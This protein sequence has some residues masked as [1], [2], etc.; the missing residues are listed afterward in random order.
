[1]SNFFSFLTLVVFLLIST[2]PSSARDIPDKPVDLGAQSFEY[3]G[4]TF[5]VLN[6]SN[7][8][9]WH[10]YWKNPGDSGLP[11]RKKFIVADDNGEE[12]K[13]EIENLE[14]P[15]PRRYIEDGDIL[16]YGHS[17]DYSLFFSPTSE[18]LQEWEGKDFTVRSSWLVCRHVCIPG[19]GEVKGQW[20]QGSFRA[21]APTLTLDRSTLIDRLNS[22]PQ[23]RDFPDELDIVLAKSSPD[24]REE[25]ALYY[26]FRTEGQIGNNR[27]L[28][29]PF[30][31]DLLGFKREYLFQDRSGHYYGRMLINWDGDFATPPVN[32]PEDGNLPTPIE[33]SFLLFNPDN[34]KTE[35]ITKTFR[36][37][38]IDHANRAE[39]L[40]SVLSTV[41]NQSGPEDISGTAAGEVRS[42]QVVDQGRTQASLLFYLVLALIG[43]AILNL[44]PCVLPVI[45]LKLFDLIKHRQKTRGQILKHN[46]A[47]TLGVLA[48][49]MA[50][51]L[52][53][54]FIK[55]TGEVVGWGFQLQSPIFVGVLI[56]A[57]FIFAL[58]LFNLYHFKTP[59]GKSLGDVKLQEGR[60]SGDFGSGVL[61][62]IL[63]TPCS[64]PFLGTALTFAFAADTLTILLMFLAIGIGLA[65]PFIVTGF[66]PAM[67]SFLPRPGM[68]MEKLKK[69]L[70][71]SLILTALWL[72]SIF[73]VLI[74]GTTEFFMLLTGLLFA[75]F[76]F[77]A[78]KDITKNL[79]FSFV[80]ALFAIIPL[81]YSLY[82]ANQQRV[83]VD[84]SAQQVREGEIRKAGLIWN[85]FSEERLE[86]H[87]QNGDVVFLNFTADWC[88]TCKVT[89]RVVINTQSFR[90]MIEQTGA[91]LMLADWTRGESYIGEWLEQHGVVGV[92]AYFAL[93]SDGTL[94]HLGET[95]TTERVRRSLK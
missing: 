46:L 14:W 36:S 92:P 43:G 4:R 1:M 90:N 87:R 25:L 39:D 61:A 28:L 7:Y 6:Y 13:V 54:I 76:Y 12:V 72:S 48:T 69:F 59:G 33:T 91:E 95:I 84:I 45:S 73:I 63:A 77:Y 19:R 57:L 62:T 49:F 44:M 29:T 52:T 30:P 41:D 56:I 9:E 79:F 31:N 5:L 17:G 60:L 3:Q 85:H 82:S 81:G 83:N 53:V 34:G 80:F 32:F 22:L 38:S 66:F 67:I 42:T 8:P 68:W 10:T 35:V 74:D 78:R 27:N 86:Q 47:Y 20:R 75:F 50:L 18:Q 11:I 64:A 88:V 55:S 24:H 26:T 21:Q 23:E 65:S 15:A 71:L 16:T 40:L 37:F 89:E 51:A 70:G 58:N 94:V 2:S 93:Q